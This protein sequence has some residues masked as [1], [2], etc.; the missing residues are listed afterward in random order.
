MSDRIAPRID[1]RAALAGQFRLD[2]K[3]VLDRK[4]V[5]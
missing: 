3:V 5:V 4:S 1:F 2:G